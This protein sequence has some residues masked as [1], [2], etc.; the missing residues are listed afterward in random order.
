MYLHISRAHL[1]VCVSVRILSL[2]PS[3]S[4]AR[5]L[6]PFISLYDICHIISGCLLLWSFECFFSFPLSL[7]FSAFFG[8][9]Y[10]CLWLVNQTAPHAL[11]A[12]GND[13][14]CDNTLL[15]CARSDSAMGYF[16]IDTLLWISRTLLGGAPPLSL[17]CTF[18]PP[19][20]DG[21][22]TEAPIQWPSLSLKRRRSSRVHSMCWRAQSLWR[23]AH[24]MEGRYT[25]ALDMWSVGCILAEL[26]TLEGNPKNKKYVIWNAILVLVRVIR[27]SYLMTQPSLRTW[28]LIFHTNPS[29]SDT[30]FVPDDSSFHT[31]MMTSYD[32]I[33]DP[34]NKLL[35]PLAI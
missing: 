27:A 3:L 21:R 7:S 24:G 25:P 20:R 28:W 2:S 15:P 4:R 35:P 14:I 26:L 11:P 19:P 18:C 22:D 16:G 13:W 34:P 23:H 6:S 30:S 10:W 29:T 1:G 9:V 32:S 17:H 8:D 33:N 12:K 5:T 31:Y